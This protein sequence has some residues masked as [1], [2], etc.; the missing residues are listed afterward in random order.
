MKLEKIMVIEDDMI[1][2][3]FISKGIKNA[4]F[5]ITGLA[6]SCQKALELLAKTKPDLILMDIGIAGDKDGI[7]TAVLINKDYDIPIIFMTGNSD[8]LTTEKAKATNPIDILLKPID[9]ARLKGK[10]LQLKDEN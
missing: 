3:L 8:C 6:R 7:E 5:E 2:Q 10:L 1:I 4:G 9:E